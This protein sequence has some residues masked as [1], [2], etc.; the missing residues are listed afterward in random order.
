[1]GTVIFLST[2]TSSKKR[3][4]LVHLEVSAL[5]PMLTPSLCLSAELSEIVEDS[6][7]LFS[8]AQLISNLTNF[9]CE[10]LK[11]GSLLILQPTGG[12]REPVSCGR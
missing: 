9:H 10:R 1:M 2:L 11:L 5:C 8:L 3:H 12:G 4:L 6:V 7:S